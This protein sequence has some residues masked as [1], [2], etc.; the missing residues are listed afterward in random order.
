MSWGASPITVALTSTQQRI[1]TSQRLA[2]H[3]PLAN[4]ANRFHFAEAVDSERFVAAF[5]RVVDQCDVLRM[6]VLPNRASDAAQ[7][8]VGPRR[9][10]ATKVI[11]MPRASVDAWATARIARPIDATACVY[12]SVLIQHDE[13][14][15]STWWLGLHHVATDAWTSALIFEA[16]ATAYTQGGDVDLSAIIDGDYFTSATVAAATPAPVGSDSEPDGAGLREP[17]S[18]YGSTS[19]HGTRIDRSELPLAAPLRSALDEALT[20]H[21]RSLSRDLSLLALSSMAIAQLVNRLDGRTVVHID[22]PLHHRSSRRHKKLVGPLMELSSLAVT[23]DQTETNAAMFKRVVRSVMELLHSSPAGAEPPARSGLLVNVVTAR[24]GDF[25]GIAATREWVRAPH[26]DATQ[27][28]GS[29]IFETSSGDDSDARL[30]WEIELPHEAAAGVASRFPE[31]LGAV[32]ADL[33]E[34]PDGLVGSSS[35]V[36]DDESTELDQLNPAPAPMALGAPVHQQVADAF[37]HRPGWV[38]AEHGTRQVSASDFDATADRVAR[39]LRSRGVVVGAPVAIRMPRSID[40]LIA[41]HAVMRAGGVFVMLDPNGPPARHEAVLED[42]DIEIV[43]DTLPSLVELE[44]VAG[45]DPLPTVGLDDLAYILFTSGSTGQPKGVPISHRGL[46]DYLRFAV[47]SFGLDQPVVA[48]H[49]SME[50]DL[51]ITSLFVSFVAGG[52]VVVFDQEPIEA[53]AAIAVD[54]R[55]DTLKATPSQLAMYCRFAAQGRPLRTVI[56]GG[57]AFRRPGAVELA[58]RCEGRVRIF[59]EYGP[60]E[61]VVGCMVHEWAADLDRGS[62]VPIGSAA[63]GAALA[64]LD[65]AQQLT[66]VGAWGELYVRRPGMATAYLGRPTETAERFVAPD[67]LRSMLPGPWYRTGDR[68]RVERPGVLVYGGRMD[69]QLKVSG[70]RLEPA[71]VEAALVAHPKVASAIV[72]L[73]SSDGPDVLTAWYEATDGRNVGTAEL[74]AHS[75]RYLADHAV[76]VAFVRVD[77]MPLAS[78]A[79]A[80]PTLLPAPQA[81]DRSDTMVPPL[82]P[83]ELAV[84]GVWCD[85]LGLAQVGA[86][87]DFFDIG[88]ASLSSIEVVAA[89]DEIFGTNLADASL[90]TARTVRTLAELI[91]AEQSGATAGDRRTPIKPLDPGTPIPLSSSEEAML[92]DY[93]RAP[94]STHYNVAR[95]YTIDGLDSIDLPALRAAFTAL[96][97]HH[98]PL[99]TSYAVGRP[100]LRADQAMSWTEHPEMSADDFD[101]LAAGSRA[102][103]FDLDAGPL[104]RIDVASTG[105]MQWSLLLCLHHVSLGVGTLDLIWR[106]AI[107]VYDGRMLP[108]LPVTY[109]A[110]AAWQRARHSGAAQAAWL[111]RA[112][113][114]PERAPLRLIAPDPSTPDGYI[115]RQLPLAP[116]ELAVDGHT[117]FSVAFAAAAVTLTRFTASSYAEFGIAASTKD[118]ADAADLIGHHLNSLPIGLEVDAAATF[119]S[120]L[121]QA[122]A[123]VASA[124]AIRTYPFAS[125]VRDARTAGCVPPDLSYMVAYDQIGAAEFPGARV[126][127]RILASNTAV[128]DV[129]FF[130]QERPDSLQ[131]SIEYRGSVI[132]AAS[133][134][135]L[136]RLFEAVLLEG[137][138]RPAS[139][140]AQLTASEPP[141]A[142]TGAAMAPTGDS[143]LHRILAA[144]LDDSEAVAVL[145]AAGEAL[146][147]G[148]L[149]ARID[150]IAQ[151]LDELSPALRIGVAVSRGL[152]VMPALLG[153]QF[154]GSAAIPL[155]P[156]IGQHRLQS[157]VVESGLDVLLHDGSIPSEVDGRILGVP[158]ERCI[159]VTTPELTAATSTLPKLQERLADVVSDD[160]A[161]VVFTSGSTGVPRGVEV[162]HANLA[163]ST[164]ARGSWYEL[165]PE[166]FLVT[167]SIGFD[168][169]VVGLY[170]PLVTGGSIVF[171]TDTDVHDVD[172]LA[173]LIERHEVSHILMVPTLYRALLDRRATALVGLD[174]AIVAGEACPPALVADHYVALPQVALVNEYG[175][176]EATVW[177]TAHRLVAGEDPVPIGGPIPGVEIRVVGEDAATVPIGVAGELCIGGPTVASGYLGATEATADRFPIRAGRR[178]YRTGDRARIVGGVAQFVG[179]LD[180]QLNVGGVR[181]EPSEI[182]AQL[183]RWDGVREAVVVAAGAPAVLVAHLVTDS[184]VEE[185]ALRQH[186]AE[187]LSA[188]A[189][190]RRFVEQPSLPLSPNGKVDRRAA[191]GLPIPVVEAPPATTGASSAADSLETGVLDAWKVALSRT[192]IDG[193]TDF[194]AVGGN[195]LAAVEIVTRLADLTGGDVPISVLLTGR[196]PSGVAALLA[197][198]SDDE[199]PAD[200]APSPCQAVTLREG[201]AK[202]PLVLMVPAWDEVF[203]YQAL[204]DAFGDEVT[205][206]A[207][208][209]VP[210][211]NKTPVDNIDDLVAGFV[212]LA[213][214]AAGEHTSIAV[215]GWSVGG[216]VAV[217]LAEELP[218]AGLAV[219]CLA[220]VD[221]LFPGEGLHLWSN[222]WWKYKSMLAPGSIGEAAKEFKIMGGRRIKRVATQLQRRIRPTAT[223]PTGTASSP[224]PS[225]GASGVFPPESLT[226]EVYGISAPLVFYAA[227]GTNPDRT[228]SHWKTVASDHTIVTVDGRHR[229]FDSIM[230]RPGV[231][232]IAAD[233]TRRL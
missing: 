62:D 199:A 161:Y 29:Q 148:V 76:P 56:V 79:K 103:P 95:L 175:P 186:L 61:A 183:L 109:G 66:P 41:I 128:T 164:F 88:G 152:H 58:E 17:I 229:G 68:A 160:I 139:T 105:P 7:A 172:R 188:A 155:D 93:R 115:A 52:R 23:V 31:H 119:G 124:L 67:A 174:V 209:H 138:A 193:S 200:T 123:E 218:A 210:L 223:T 198:R 60:T 178:W 24:Y 49:S 163:A 87:D 104:M 26:V 65:S 191:A 195:S 158:A 12:D 157:I 19:T 149:A 114:R 228:I 208:I 32:F 132:N 36:T 86:T 143:V 184:P 230:S 106:Q 221:T 130:V 74:R 99:H 83:T 201:S 225:V 92:F 203:G 233:L 11:N 16:T 55:I 146:T 156:S 84:A 129:T 77:E 117:A 46:A 224:A 185:A 50:F 159:D 202:G 40:T 179:R 96:A 220:L 9:A 53:L 30:R 142:L 45:S 177:A 180:D 47:E 116:S 140:V 166:R 153:A 227:T 121:V 217:E 82:G 192:D 59:N 38:V 43:I 141:S 134:E 214:D 226:H 125:M 44:S 85:V 37:R 78:S 212:P 207:L 101:L 170:W 28:V 150:R 136:L 10:S 108:E 42:A 98:E 107:D 168:S 75:R 57:E 126:Q 63:P 215:L 169:S 90:F 144:A 154:A 167:S 127:H 145:D 69:D 25:A 21:Y 187:H 54:D 206:V 35:V 181:V 232:V 20:S 33:L 18:L 51:T 216:V 231:D 171:P 219:C 151:R 120:L 173:Q 27:V 89:L 8:T 6:A 91:D 189:V 39:W 48:L 80:D 70:F 22:T 94:A 135:R 14:N 112:E 211:A 81:M 110:H 4:M 196:T 122:G 100:A 182:E 131:L 13:D 5:D 2:A 176:T 15:T 190:P 97:G 72:R 162:T 137:V 118:H 102:V 111:E 133:A 213:T 222:R 204:A 1:W 3:V 205:V 194:F 113:R 73:W 165:A 34:R 147:R 64:L 71:E 197:V